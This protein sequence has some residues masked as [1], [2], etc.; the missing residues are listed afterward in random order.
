MKVID[1]D[2]KV[3]EMVSKQ[4]EGNKETNRLYSALTCFSIPCNGRDTHTSASLLSLMI[5]G[6]LGFWHRR[7]FHDGSIGPFRSSRKGPGPDGQAPF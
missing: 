4:D 7:A 2:F 3:A 5:V 6:P 1:H